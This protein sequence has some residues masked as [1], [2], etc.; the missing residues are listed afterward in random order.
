MALT[1]SKKQEVLGSLAEI[2]KGAKTLV[3]VKFDKLSVFNSNALRRELRQNDSGLRVAKKRLLLRALDEGGFKGEVPT[4]E[5]EVMLAYSADELAPAQKVYDFQKTHKDNISIVGG[6]FD[7]S[8]MNQVEM[9]N[10]A[11]IPGMQ[12]LRGMFVNVINSPIQRFA[13]ALSEVAK[14]QG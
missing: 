9:M 4:I 5:G 2:I 14:K 13:I 3:F 7:G 12:G 11:T 10:I 1:K 6:V 8:Y